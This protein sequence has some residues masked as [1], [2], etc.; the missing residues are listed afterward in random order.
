MTQHSYIGLENLALTAPQKTTLV[1]A[2]ASLG[3]A[4]DPQPCNRNHR[5]VRTDQ[6]AVIFEAL[7]QDSDLTTLALRQYLANVFGVALA[8]VTA[9]TTSQTFLTLPSPIITLTYQATAR[10]RFVLFGG[11]GATWQQS[12]AETAAYLAANAVAWGDV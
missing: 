9:A 4:S 3:P 12:R 11:V 8:N 6:D 1:Q 2:L 5:R 7:F 10:L